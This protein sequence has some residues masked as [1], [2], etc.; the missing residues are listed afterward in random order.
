MASLVDD[1]FAHLDAEARARSIAL[2]A[3]AASGVSVRADRDVL[4]IVLVNLVRNAIRHSGGTQVDVRLDASTLVVSDDGRGFDATSEPAQRRRAGE[5][6]SSSIGLGLSI[7]E[8][9]C[10]G[11]GWTIA[12][13]S[14]P[15]CG[16]RVAV[17]FA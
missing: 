6:E 15:G 14:D 8:R 12:I 9:I 13:D 11:A 10:E 4:W 1:V 3:S 5:A 7:V 16:T 17:G 2:R